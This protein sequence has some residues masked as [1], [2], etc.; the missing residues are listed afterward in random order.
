MILETIVIILLIIILLVVSHEM[1]HFFVAK[2]FNVRVDEFGVGIPPRLFGKKIGETL[3]SVNL[4]PFGGFVKIFGEDDSV[5]EPRSFA[6]QSFRVRSLIVVAGVLA[7][8]FVGFLIFSF[9]AWYG[10][11]QFLVEV[12]GVAEG[13]PAQ[14]AGFRSGDI[15]AGFDGVEQKTLEVFAVESYIEDRREKDASFVVRRGNERVVLHGIPRTNP[16]SGQ[17]ALGVVIGP[18]EVGISRVAWY[19]VPFEGLAATLKMLWLIVAGLGYFFKELF[20][21]GNAPGE[22]LGPVGIAQVAKETFHIGTYYFLQL[23]GL[24]SLNLAV[25]NILPIP[26]L[27]GGRLLFFIIEKIKGTPIPTHVS[28]VLHSF[29]MALLMMLLL[30]I[31]W[32][33]I[34]RLI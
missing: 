11:P 17:G 6:A 24:L 29:F 13:S 14:A 18:K 12:A 32:R 9:L 3:Y 5:D 21:H 26:A 19:Q 33:D 23:V 16:P 10:M 34:A 2:W 25:M 27:D 1:G 15:I 20:T 4:L 7:N 8:I 28:R 22:V 30:W 31:T